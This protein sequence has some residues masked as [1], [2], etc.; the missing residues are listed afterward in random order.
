MLCLLEIDF[1]YSKARAKIVQAEEKSVTISSHTTFPTYCEALKVGTIALFQINA[2]EL[3]VK[4]HVSF[5][6]LC[7]TDIPIDKTLHA[8]FPLTITALHEGTIAYF[9]VFSIILIMNLTFAY[10]RVFVRAEILSLIL[11][12]QTPQIQR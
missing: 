3:R 1:E 7:A 10:Q 9:H 8:I 12:S 6:I 2:V 11:F 4:C 5:A